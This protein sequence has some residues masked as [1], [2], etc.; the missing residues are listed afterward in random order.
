[1]LTNPHDPQ[2]PENAE[3]ESDESANK[4]KYVAVRQYR[5]RSAFERMD[6]A[7]YCPERDLGHVGYPMVRAAMYAFDEQHWEPWFREFMTANAVSELDLGH[8]AQKLAKAM[9]KIITTANPVVAL[10][11]EGFAAMPP[12]VQMAIYTRIGQVFLAAI[13]EGVKDLTPENGA[14]PK[15][16]IDIINAVDDFMAGLGVK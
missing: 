5:P 1:M 6:R 14:P 13:W 9:S 15:S 10:E 3:V 4:G 16:H 8:A 7:F 2:L 11:A 12:A